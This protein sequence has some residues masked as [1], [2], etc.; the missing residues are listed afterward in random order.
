M[1]PLQN[2]QP[3]QSSLFFLVDGGTAQPTI[4]MDEIYGIFIAKINNNCIFKLYTIKPYILYKILAFH[5]NRGI[6]IYISQVSL[7]LG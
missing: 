7:Q 4:S 5:Q 6:N 1:T 2:L 3:N